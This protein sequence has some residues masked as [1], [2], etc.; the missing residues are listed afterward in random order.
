MNY[1]TPAEKAVA[2]QLPKASQS[3]YWACKTFGDTHDE[4]MARVNESTRIKNTYGGLPAQE[5]GQV[6]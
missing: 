4:A 6:A 5:L 1:T 2:D 3:L